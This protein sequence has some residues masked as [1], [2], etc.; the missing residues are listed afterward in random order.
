MQKSL[1][2]KKNIITEV[3]YLY[4]L[5]VTLPFSSRIRRRRRRERYRPVRYR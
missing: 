2:L 5:Y 4:Q 1:D 3:I